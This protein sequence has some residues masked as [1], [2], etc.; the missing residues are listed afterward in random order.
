MPVGRDR[1][2]LSSEPNKRLNLERWRTK[3]LM[4][5]VPYVPPLGVP[6]WAAG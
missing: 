2:V 1:I 5:G 6:L 3:G 4:C